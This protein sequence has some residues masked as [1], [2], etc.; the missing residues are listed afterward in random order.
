MSATAIADVFAAWNVAELES[1][2]IE[3]RAIVLAKRDAAGGACLPDEPL[4]VDAAQLRERGARRLSRNCADR[5]R[6]GLGRCVVESGA[7]RNEYWLFFFRMMT[8][9]VN[10]P[11]LPSVS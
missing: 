3:I 5:H 7:A 4:A 9:R 11:L 2:L 1:Y 10:W 8:G 6:Y